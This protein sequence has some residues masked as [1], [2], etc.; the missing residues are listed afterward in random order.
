M[1]ARVGRRF[2][3]APRMITFSLDPKDSDVWTGDSVKCKTDLIEQVGGGYPTLFY[4]ILTAGESRNFN[5]TA[6]EHTYGAA[7]DGDED[8]ED[9]NVRL[10]YLTGLLDQLKPD[11][12]GAARTLREVYLAVFGAGVIDAGL[13]IRFIF[14][15]NCVAGSG[16]NTLYSVKTGAWP[17]LSTPILIQNNGLIVGKGGD[18]SGGNGGP[19]LQLQANIRLKNFNIIGGGGGA[20]GSKTQ[21]SGGTTA[22][23]GGGGGAG[24]LL[25]IANP[26][27]TSPQN[28]EL[29]STDGKNGTYTSGGNAGSVTAFTSDGVTTFTVNAGAGGD[30]GQA[31]ETPSGG[32]AGGLAGKAIDL[33]GFVITYENTGTILGAVS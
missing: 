11:S 33:N 7:V 30:L 1:S 6:L 27:F 28:R 5:Y 18:A 25:G 9:P 31:G 8:V 12:G 26:S 24:Y 14:E 21:V 3:E 22:S 32:D 17:E 29:D 2:A 10:V 23:A 19:A 4:Q 16:D 13:D 15:S 20:G